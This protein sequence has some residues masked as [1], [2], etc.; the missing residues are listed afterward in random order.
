MDWTTS[1]ECDLDCEDGTVS[2]PHQAFLNGVFHPFDL[3]SALH[4]GC[5][6]GL[7]VADGD[8]I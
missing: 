4:L 6:H 3:P 7:D 1:Y 2:R 8:W 5:G